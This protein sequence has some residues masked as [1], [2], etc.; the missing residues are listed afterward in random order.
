MIFKEATETGFPESAFAPAAPVT[1]PWLS[2]KLKTSLSISKPAP[3]RPGSSYNT[4]WKR[5]RILVHVFVSSV[6]WFQMHFIEL[7]YSL[8]DT[9]CRIAV[10]IIDLRSDQIPTASLS[11]AFLFLTNILLWF[12]VTTHE[13]KN[14]S[15]GSAEHLWEHYLEWL[16]FCFCN[17]LIIVLTNVSLKKGYLSFIL[18]FENIYC[19]R[20]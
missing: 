16:D 1:S 7:K 19:K 2:P 15:L 6:L 4:A 11:N 12:S 17:C 13:V 20:L 3:A 5:E 14:T 9:G 8:C 10:W 18:R